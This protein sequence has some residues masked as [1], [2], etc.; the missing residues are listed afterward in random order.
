M[1]ARIES[2]P[3]PEELKATFEMDFLP[4]L[5]TRLQSYFRNAYDAEELAAEA[6]AQAWVMFVSAKRRAQPVTPSTLAYYAAKAARA[7]RKLTGSS[8]LD[9]MSKSPLARKRIGSHVSLAQVGEGNF[10]QVFGDRRSRFSAIDMVAIKM[11]W[12]DFAVHLCDDRDRSIILHR[13]SGLPKS[14]IADLLGISR[15]AI[16]QRLSTML[17]RWMATSAA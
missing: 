15:P 14:K 6:I 9:A 11:D 2:T 13:L 5:T 16:S 12:A 7:D 10:Y 4:T 8:S 3:S 17:H 1:I